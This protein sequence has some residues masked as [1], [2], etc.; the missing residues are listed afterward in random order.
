[1]RNRCCQEERADP[2][3]LDVLERPPVVQRVTVRYGSKKIVAE[4]PINSLAAFRASVLQQLADSRIN[5]PEDPEPEFRYMDAASQWFIVSPV[6]LKD[7]A[8]QQDPLEI[9]VA[10]IRDHAASSRSIGQHFK[11][12][13][14]DKRVFLEIN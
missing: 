7:F 12:H 6:A 13:S 1:M 4:V 5:V 3:H 8:T 14:V 2:Y 11:S 9:E 10:I